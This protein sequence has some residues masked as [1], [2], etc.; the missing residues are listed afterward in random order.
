MTHPIEALLETLPQLNATVNLIDTT[1]QKI[2]QAAVLLCGIANEKVDHLDKLQDTA[3]TFIAEYIRGEDRHELLHNPSKWTARLTR[4]LVT[5][6]NEVC[7]E[8]DKGA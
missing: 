5:R 7:I 1:L 8:I 4:D 2:S 6:L 3:T